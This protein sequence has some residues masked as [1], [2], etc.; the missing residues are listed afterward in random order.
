MMRLWSIVRVLRLLFRFKLC[1]L[2]HI[3]IDI[4]K[5]WH[6]SCYKLRA[7]RY[8]VS[9]LGFGAIMMPFELRLIMSRLQLRSLVYI[10]VDVR[11]TGHHRRYGF[12]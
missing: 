9:M 6:C 11:K 5:T 3:F 7:N 1:S 4:R 8:G 12:G 2:M 10:F